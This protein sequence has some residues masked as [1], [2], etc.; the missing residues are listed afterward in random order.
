ME[1]QT[2]FNTTFRHSTT[3]GIEDQEHMQLSVYNYLCSIITKHLVHLLH[4]HFTDC[5]FHR[6]VDRL[7][8]L[9]DWCLCLFLQDP[10]RQNAIEESTRW[11]KTY[12]LT[13]NRWV[14]FLIYQL[15]Q[16]GS[17][18]VHWHVTLYL[19]IYT[20]S[21][22][23]HE[24]IRMSLF[25]MCNGFIPHEPMKTSTCKPAYTECTKNHKYTNNELKSII[26]MLFGICKYTLLL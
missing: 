20:Q 24:N 2:Y 22:V 21:Y 26:M 6:V 9:N 1:P 7:F 19:K 8:R 17:I 3:T 10:N 18:L 12:W 5:T 23:P 14:Q 4:N 16:L 25:F 11:T 15:K 13:H